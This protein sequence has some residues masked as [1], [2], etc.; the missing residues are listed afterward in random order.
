[1]SK[2]YTTWWL[3]AALTVLHFPVFSQKYSIHLAAFTEQIE[4]SFFS[5]AGF[6]EVQHQQHSFNFHQYTWGSFPTLETAQHQL[7]TLQQNPL[8]QGLS[9]LSIKPLVSNFSI[10]TTDSSAEAVVGV[11]DF[12]L[13]SRSVYINSKTRG[14]Q[15]IDVAILEE[16]ANILVKYPDLKLRVLATN[17]KEQLVEASSTAIV[18]NFLLAQNIPAYRIKTMSNGAKNTGANNITHQVLPKQQVILTLVDLKEE[19]VLDK[20]MLND[21][22]VKQAPAKNSL[23]LLE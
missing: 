9:N 4:P 2:T 18:E 6:S 7:T 1:M 10:P 20:F 16:V 22:I 17:Q 5:Y 23:N 12:Q 19:I 8:L 21:F 15:K 13:F 11:T 14:L 3:L